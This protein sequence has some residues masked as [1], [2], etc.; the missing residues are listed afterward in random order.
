MRGSEGIRWICEALAARGPSFGGM[1]GRAPSEPQL[2]VNCHSATAALEFSPGSAR[3][4]VIPAN[5]CWVAMRFVPVRTCCA[6][7]IF[8][9]VPVGSDDAGCHLHNDLL[10]LLRFNLPWPQFEIFVVFVV[11]RQHRY[12]PSALFL[13]QNELGP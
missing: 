8:P 9:K 12:H 13:I 7:S 6:L 10:A 4:L 3:T 5:F 2:S 1:S 11:K